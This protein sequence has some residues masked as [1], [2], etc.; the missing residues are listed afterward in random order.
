AR[1][2]RADEK[3]PEVDRL[4]RQAHSLMRFSCGAPRPSRCQPSLGHRASATIEDICW[5]IDNP[6]IFVWVEDDKIVG[7]SAA[8]LR[9]VAAIRRKSARQPLDPIG[10]EI[11]PPKLV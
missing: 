7:F 3:V 1:L 6:G 8:D 2:E 10:P 5:S 9:A 11:S 4:W